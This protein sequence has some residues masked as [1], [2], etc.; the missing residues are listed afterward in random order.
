MKPMTP[1]TLYEFR[2]IQNLKESPSGQS[3]AYTLAKANRE[4]NTYH[5]TLYVNDGHNHKIL[6]MKDQDT[7]VFETETTLLVSY[8]RTK[9]DEAL[10]KEKRT[11]VYRYDLEQKTICD[12]YCFDMPATILKVL[13]KR[14]LLLT[15]TLAPADHV[16]YKGSSKE[17]KAYLEHI[18]ESK[19]IMEISAIPF[20]F[21]GTGFTAG[22]TKQLFLYDTVL[23]T[24]VPLVK[25]SFSYGL[26]KVSPDHKRIYYTGT[27]DTGIRGQTTG[28]YVYDR[29]TKTTDALYDTL[30][31]AIRTMILFKDKVVVAATDMETFGLNQNSDFFEVKNKKMIPFTTFSG[32]LGSS[33]GTDVRLAGSAMEAMGSDHYYFV[34]TKGEG[35]VLTSLDKNG[36]MTE[37][38]TFKGS[39]DGI[40]WTDGRLL[41]VGLMGQKLQEIY[42]LD[43]ETGKA[44]AI[45]R[46]NSKVLEDRY[47]AKPQPISVTYETH[48]VDGW[49]LYPKA[50][51]SNKMYPAILDIHGGPKTVYGKVFFHEMQVWANQ[52]YFVMFC[53][54]R[55]SDG[56]GNAFADIRGQYGTI[57]YEDIM[58]FMKRV[59]KKIKTID[60]QQ[61]FVTG[62]SYGGF[63]TNWI[64]GQTTMFKAAVTQRSI[65]NWLSFYGTSDIGYGFAFDQAKGH[66]VTDTTDLW[67]QSPLAYARHVKTPLLFIH[68]D[69][70]Y[71]CPIEQAMQFYTVLKEQG[72]KTKLLWFKEENHELSR[73]GKPKARIK[74]LEAI[75]DWFSQNG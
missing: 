51:D 7:F 9:Q 37:V 18:E 3:F 43:L 42:H 56:K 57:D 74:R 46:F 31:H 39:I 54:P 53:N 22:K 19:D 55:G 6:K 25:P 20:Y 36:K 61:L 29:E 62:G 30:D 73:S 68:S 64:V 21:N 4:H 70:D 66:P 17:R 34:Q 50:Y 49:V 48:T 45:T 27:T 15:S 12:A 23:K 8:Q 44:K 2:F 32:S 1:E 33:V 5:H 41:G 75:T 63:M 67:R 28:V 14:T 59:M 10:K 58:A 35:T 71:R 13:D 72:L 38:M 16:L 60:P 26:V 52:G 11:K 47:V 69:A 65:S 24:F 40:I